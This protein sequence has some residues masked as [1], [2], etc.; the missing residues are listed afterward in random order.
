[1]PVI[2]NIMKPFGRKGYKGRDG[3]RLSLLST[4]YKIIRGFAKKS[5]AHWPKNSCSEKKTRPLSKID[6][7]S[8]FFK[9]IPVVFYR[10]SV[11]ICEK[12]IF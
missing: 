8:L 10:F 3:P 11:E 6:I 5:A 1:M 9:I 4:S 2:C 12:S 7:Y